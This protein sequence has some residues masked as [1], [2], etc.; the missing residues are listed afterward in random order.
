MGH[1]MEQLQRE[2]IKTSGS[3]QDGGLG[4]KVG[5]TGDLGDGEEGKGLA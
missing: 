4:R 1:Q 3:W 5:D 2:E